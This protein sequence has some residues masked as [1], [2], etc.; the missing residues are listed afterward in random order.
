MSN[1][2][3]NPTETETAITNGVGCSNGNNQI[4]Q[5]PTEDI[6]SEKNTYDSNGQHSYHKNDLEPEA[7]RKVFIGG[8][9]YKTEDQSFKD[10]FSNYGDIV[11][12]TRERE[13]RTR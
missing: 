13:S 7:L 1:E 5:Q 12:S 4:E 6:Q 10:Y 2:I 3:L 9:S 11:V 8:L